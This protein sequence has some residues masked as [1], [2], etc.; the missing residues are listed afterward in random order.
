MATRRIKDPIT[1]QLTE[2]QIVEINEEENN[3]I[4][5][6]LEDGAVLRLKIDIAQ[7]V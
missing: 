2:A 5:L 7:V 3:A 1:G 6:K 4:I